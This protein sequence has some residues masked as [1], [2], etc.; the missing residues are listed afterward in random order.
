VL[1]YQRGLFLPEHGVS[2]LE[3]LA[4]EQSADE[5]FLALLRRFEREG[6]NVSDKLPLLCRNGIYQRKRGQ[7]EQAS[8]DRHGRRNAQAV[9]RGQ[10]PRRDLRAAGNTKSADFFSQSASIYRFEQRFPLLT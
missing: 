5:A 6:R 7:R 1:H 2:S 9:R 4:R 8:Q 10:N 3:K